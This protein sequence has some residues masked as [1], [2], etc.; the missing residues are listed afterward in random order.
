VLSKPQIFRQ[1]SIA[2]CGGCGNRAAAESSST[3]GASGAKTARRSVGACGGGRSEVCVA[4]W[5]LP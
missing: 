4:R 5:I 2:K 1:M 3:L